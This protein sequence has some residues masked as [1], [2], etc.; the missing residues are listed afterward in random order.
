[1]ITSRALAATG[2]L[3]LAL[4][5]C[6]GDDGDTSGTGGSGS[7]GTSS[8]SAGSSSGG[9]SAGTGGT[10]STALP[11]TVPQEMT[12]AAFTTFMDGAA[13]TMNGWVSETAAP[14][15]AAN[16]VSPHV[17]VRVWFNPTLVE[18]VN[19]GNGVDLQA[20]AHTVG[21]MSV[22]EL[23]DDAD[24]LVGHAVSLK[25]EDGKGGTSW[26]YYCKGPN[27][28]CYSGSTGFDTTPMFAKGDLQ[29]GGCH[30]GMVFTPVP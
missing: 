19:A 25:V 29:C 23:Y 18:S 14:R 1:M 26:Q 10:G 17:R 13:Y 22:K 12:A 30:G 9:S 24:A 7:G 16:T 15:A 3:V 21:S 27:G 5:G 8:G 4:S 2:F 20:P 6:G 11:N 28:R